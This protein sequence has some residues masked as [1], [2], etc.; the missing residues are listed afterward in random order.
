M[1]PLVVCGM[2]VY[3]LVHLSGCLDCLVISLCVCP[4]G[5]VPAACPCRDPCVT[6][7]HG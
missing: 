4:C 5:V 7:S 2:Y 6:L 1:F 3:V